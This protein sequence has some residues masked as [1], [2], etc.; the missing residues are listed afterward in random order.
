HEETV[1]ASHEAGHAVVALFCPHARA[2]ERIALSD[3]VVGAL[4]YVRHKDPTHRHVHTREQ[5]LA[6]VCVLYGGVEAEKLLLGDN[7]S[8]GCAQDLLQ[9]TEIIRDLVEI[10]G[11]GGVTGVGR[12][13]HADGQHRPAGLSQIKL[14]ELDRR[15][16]DLLG[17]ARDR[18]VALL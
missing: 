10:Y 7:P 13:R 14:A 8:W 3:D 18:A 1:I 2:I 15:V 6:D 12:Y 17:E 11:M 16:D 5:M 4:G 9:A